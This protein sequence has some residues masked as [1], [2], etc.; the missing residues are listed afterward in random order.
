MVRWKLN[1]EKNIQLFKTLDYFRTR[2]HRKVLL[3]KSFHC[4][5]SILYFYARL[6]WG[7]NS[8]TI[9][10]AGLAFFRGV[11]TAVEHR[12]HHTCRRWHLTKKPSVEKCRILK[13]HIVMRTQT[14]R[15]TKSDIYRFPTVLMLN[16][17]FLW[18]PC[19]KHCDNEDPCVIVIKIMMIYD[20]KLL[21]L[22]HPCD[23]VANAK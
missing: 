14:V 17:A 3:G 4:D 22:S 1:N 7:L 10:S 16:S 5:V 11:L 23:V 12:P 18:V 19:Q 9:Y 21:L 8:Q 15:G 20:R 2:V 6:L 13:T